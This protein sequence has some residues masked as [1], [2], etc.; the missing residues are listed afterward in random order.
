ML[1]SPSIWKGMMKMPKNNPFEL[2]R[3][4]IR[5]VRDS[6]GPLISDTPLNSPKQVAKLLHDE[7][8]ADLD[9]DLNCRIRGI[10]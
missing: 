4:S 5:L 2:D 10:F 7:I 8:F 9:T 1:F 6:G 3:V